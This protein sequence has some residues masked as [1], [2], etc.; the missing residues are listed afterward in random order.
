[1]KLIKALIGGFAGAIAL[2]LLHET[3]R[4]F[5]PKAPRVDLV[6]AE[7]LTKS[8]S[9]LNVDPP[10]G[11]KLYAATLAGDVLSNGMYYSAIGIGNPKHIWLR[12]A[13]TGLSAGIGA[14]TLPGP[15]GLEDAPVT[16]TDQTKLLTVSWYL[17]GAL[18]TAAVL[19]KMKPK[20]LVD[21]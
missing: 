1:M 7:A 17:F 12:A 21:L 8:L 19:S 13:I 4:Q 11:D 15:M 20:S 10:K 2:N 16:R 5:D 14:L 18:V 9:A 3:V 6:G